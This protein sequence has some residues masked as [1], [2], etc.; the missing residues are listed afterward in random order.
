MKKEEKK[1]IAPNAEIVEFIMDDIITISI[2][3]ASIPGK[4]NNFLEEEEE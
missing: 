3:E 4:P 2:N 1:F